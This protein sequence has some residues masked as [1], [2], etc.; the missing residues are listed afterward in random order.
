MLRTVEKTKLESDAMPKQKR[1][2]LDAF[3]VL[4]VGGPAGGMSAEWAI[5]Y[6]RFSEGRSA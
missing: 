1:D 4:S 6:A 2:H 3:E 5:D